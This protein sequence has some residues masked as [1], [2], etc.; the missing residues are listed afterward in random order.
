LPAEITG[1]VAKFEVLKHDADIPTS[2]VVAGC[3][4]ETRHQIRQDHTIDIRQ[5]FAFLVWPVTPRTNLKVNLA[6][7]SLRRHR[8]TLEQCPG[9]I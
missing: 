8:P 7:N 3:V 1:Q 5:Q 9:D 4:L 2:Q 6:N